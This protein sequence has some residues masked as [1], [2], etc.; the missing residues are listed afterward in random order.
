MTRDR[1]IE[2]DG[3]DDDDWHGDSSGRFE[4][5]TTQERGALPVSSDR[6]NSRSV[7][8]TAGSKRV[9]RQISQKAGGMH[10]RRNRKIT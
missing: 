8:E 1:R 6:R 4:K 9:R 10:R 2:E 7:K 3:W 5:F